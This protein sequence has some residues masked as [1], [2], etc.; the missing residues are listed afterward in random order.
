MG[1]RS[2]ISTSYAYSGKFSSP[3]L[4]DDRLDVEIQDLTPAFSRNAVAFDKAP[5]FLY[6]SQS[7]FD[8]GGGLRGG[9]QVL[10]FNKLCAFR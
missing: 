9:G 7:G 3:P 4:I 5:G 8:A 2:C 1:V 6:E 10:H